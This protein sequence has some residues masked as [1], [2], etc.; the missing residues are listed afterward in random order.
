MALARYNLRVTKIEYYIIND[1]FYYND[2]MIMMI[3]D[4][5]INSLEK[6]FFFKL[7]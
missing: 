3:Y 5:S 2:D 4:F 7:L 1:A 6:N